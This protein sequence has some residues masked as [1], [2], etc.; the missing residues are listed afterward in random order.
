MPSPFPLLRLPRLVLFEVFKS[1][2][3]GEK[4]ELS[5]CSTQISTQINN[6]QFYSQKVIVCLDILTRKIK[7]HSENNKDTFDIFMYPDLWR[8][9]NSNT[10]QLSIARGTVPV[11]PHTKGISAFWKNDR[12]E[13]LSAIRY[14]LKMFQCK[15]SINMKHYSSGL[16]GATISML[17]DL[18]VEFKK[19]SISLNGSEDQNLLWNQISNKLGLVEDLRITSTFNTDFIPV[20]TSWPQNITITRSHWFTLKSLLACSCTTITLPWSHLENE[21][22][23]EI[24]K[25]WKAGG[26][27]NLKNLRVES[28]R[29][30]NN[31][32][33]I[34][35]M[36]L[37][38]LDGKDIQT[39]DGLRKATINT[40]FQMFQMFFQ[41]LIYSR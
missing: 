4:I 2:S 12:E 37:S 26:F 23:D 30:T 13:Y 6:A 7:V 3:I 31:G 39:N 33:T 36:S 38:E 20:F 21:D 34:L 5:L 32:T 25:N 16:Y 15:I 1:L 11:I 22:L 18:Q 28:Q 35:G 8:S 41:M 17:F 14:L 24:L 19:L 10:H 27:L 9:H 29:I 40:G